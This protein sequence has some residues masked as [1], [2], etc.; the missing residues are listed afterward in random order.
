MGYK[1][2]FW[3]AKISEIGFNSEFKDK[4][5][6]SSRSRSFSLGS[7]FLTE[8]WGWGEVGSLKLLNENFDVSQDDATSVLL[9]PGVAW[10][11]TWADDTIYTRQG[12]KLSLSL[13]GATSAL[14][15]DTSFVQMVVRGKYIYSVTDNGRLITRGVLG[16]TEVTDF[17]KLPSSLRFFAGGD[18]SLRGFDFESL[19]PI[20][21]D[22]QVNGGRY[23]AVGSVEYEHML[24]GKWGAAIF[25]D[26]GNAIDRWH[27]PFEYSVGVGLRWRSPIGLI[28]LDVAKGLSDP[29]D[30]FGI[31]FV[32][33]PDL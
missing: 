8:R 3:S 28:R 17:K 27:D 11:K 22:G 18:S 24:F 2:P 7:Y 12:G 30:P 4:N 5:T 13:S 26:F 9:I 23:L 21:D 31:H 10:S 19:G 15:S 6:D 1:M 32:I 33:G 25:S 14:L 20:G 29:E 16:A